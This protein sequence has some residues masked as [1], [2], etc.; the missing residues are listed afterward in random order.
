MYIYIYLLTKYDFIYL[1]K[2]VILKRSLLI[3]AAKF[4][5]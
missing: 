4:I 3:M 5:I 2:T 1:K